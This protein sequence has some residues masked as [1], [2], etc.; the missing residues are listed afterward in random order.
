MVEDEEELRMKVGRREAEWARW[1]VRVGVLSDSE[2]K[3][4]AS[5]ARTRD[6]ELSRGTGHVD[7]PPATRPTGKFGEERY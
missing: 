6:G 4:R 3:T 2:D 1:R 7:D 5:R